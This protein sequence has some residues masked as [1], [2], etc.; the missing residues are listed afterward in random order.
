MKPASCVLV[1]AES[2]ARLG[3]WVVDQQFMDVMGSPFLLAHGLGVPVAPAETTVGLPLAGRYR[4]WVRTR[5]WVAPQGPGRFRVH[6]GGRPLA[7]E[8]GVGG[9]GTWQWV[10]GGAVELPCGPAAL[11]LED[12]TGFA[13]RC[14]ALLFVHDGA[15]DDPPP[16]A[17]A[18]LL[19]CRDACA[20]RPA[21]PADAGAF[22]FVVAGGGYAGLCAAI[23]A[24]R[25]GLRVALLHDRPVLGGNA[26]SEVRV[27]PIGAVE[28]AL[29]PRTADILQE[30][31]RT[32]RGVSGSGGIRAN[33]DDDYVA[34]L[35]AREPQ[36]RVFLD[37]H[38]TAVERDGA[39]L[40]ALR[41]RHT[42]SGA[43]QRFPAP[44]FADCTGDAQ[45]GFL[46]GADWRLGREGRD[47]T[48]EALAPARGDRQQLGASNFWL[49]A[50][51]GRPTTFPACPWALP[52][53]SLDAM[54]VATP[55]WP[56]RFGEHAYAAGWNW[57]TGFTMDQLGDAEAV[58]DHNFRA[59]YGAWDFLKNRSDGRAAYA[60]AALSWV[61][62]ILGRRES[63]RLLGDLIL[64]EH[65]LT[66]PRYYP[67]GCVTTTWYLDLHFPHPQNSRFFPG[68]E[69]RSLA[70]DDPNF[71]RFRGAIVG[72]HTEIKPYPVPYRCFYSRNVPNLFMAGR[73]ISV[74]HVALASVRV[75]NTTALMG[76]VVGRAAALCCRLGVE[77]RALA[78]T[79]WPALHA[80]LSDP[81]AA[82]CA[83]A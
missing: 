35:A 10:D 79:H 12:L 78:T 15:P 63:R 48:G 81:Q 60:D 62:Y 7:R 36:L 6:V 57:E 50:H 67:D 56:P 19:A 71:E 21:T 27:T 3:G 23:A 53:P 40:V 76:T 24:A 65:D 1:E 32:P 25:L 34:Q 30:L 33:V 61:A 11:V 44:L 73:N 52:I 37:T 43:E 4:L 82:A 22:D 38:V 17:P 68:R 42:R 59:I 29:Y 39:R 70:Y 72:Q 31:H 69:F 16:N 2:F 66:A 13:A 47:E 9:D 46:A 18:A 49:A 51:T 5:D 75:M 54:E 55:K 26:S 28:L 20:G 8:F 45:V 83:R 64:T 74:T 77:P 80:L 14:D 41:A 58:R